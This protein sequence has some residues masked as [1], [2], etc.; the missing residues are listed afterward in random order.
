M[1][2]L[3]LDPAVAHACPGC[4]EAAAGQKGAA[5]GGE[6]APRDGG[7]ISRVSEGY[8]YTIY[9]LIA[10]PFTLVAAGGLWIHLAFKRAAR[11]GARPAHGLTV[12]TPEGAATP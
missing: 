11:E 8:S 2:A 4:K 7:E 1:L 5:G 3:G 10:L 6:G 9:G 12:P